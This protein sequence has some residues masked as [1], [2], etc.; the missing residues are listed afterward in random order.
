[1]EVGN[2]QDFAAMNQAI[3]AHDIHPVI[4]KTFSLAQVQQAFEYLQQGQH[5]GKV[6]VVF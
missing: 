4:D 3:E 2:T 5:F 1:M 6:V